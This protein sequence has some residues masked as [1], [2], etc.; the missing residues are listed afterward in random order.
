[1]AHKIREAM[2]SEADGAT[3]G[4]TVEVD[5]AYFGGH[6]RPA[7]RKENRRDRRLVPNQTGKRRV[8]VIMR[9]R[10]GRTLPFVAEHRD[11]AAQPAAICFR[12]PTL[13]PVE[14]FSAAA[15]SA[16]GTSLKPG[17]GFAR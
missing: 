7:N 14:C 16:A 3:V 1:M 12:P 8:V 13:E 17:G 9:E 6:V 5:G 2:A 10:G 11:P 15:R 4:G